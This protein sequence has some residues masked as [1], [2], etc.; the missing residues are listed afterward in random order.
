MRRHRA[1]TCPQTS[2]RSCGRDSRRRPDPRRARPPRDP[3]RPAGRAVP[4]RP[5]RLAR[6]GSLAPDREARL[7]AL[8]PDWLLPYG[9]DWHRKYHLLRHHL[10]TGHDPATVTRDLVIDKAKAGGWLHRQYTAW[11]RLQQG[12]RTLLTSLGLTPTRTPL[13]PGTESGPR[14]RRGF[15]QSA[16]LLRAFVERHGRTPGAREWIEADGERAMIGPWWCRTRIKQ[17]AGHLSADHLRLIDEI[18]PAATAQPRPSG[19]SEPPR[20]LAARPEDQ[21]GG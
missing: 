1:Q 20:D 9:P 12:Q 6:K 5:A 21:P 16:A 15:E 8:D 11:D 4:R 18:L 17:T 3:R 7:A 13:T 19:Q 2:S 10:E 14:R